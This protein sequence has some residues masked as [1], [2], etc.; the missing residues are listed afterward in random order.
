M[1]L[2]P[3][4][5]LWKHVWKFMQAYYLCTDFEDEEICML[6]SICSDRKNERIPCSSLYVRCELDHWTNN[7]KSF[8][9]LS[10]NGISNY[11]IFYNI[12]LWRH[13]CPSPDL[14]VWGPA[15]AIIVLCCWAIHFTLTVPLS[16]QV[17]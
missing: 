13:A 12:K 5:F 14:V 7:C 16:T 17:Y 4:Q 15:L 2:I 10:H 1:V 6:T 11:T 3:P 9:W 8:Y